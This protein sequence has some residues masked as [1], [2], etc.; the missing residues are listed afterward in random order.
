METLSD[1]RKTYGFLVHICYLFLLCMQYNLDT[2]K[3]GT[4]RK[5]HHDPDVT[6]SDVKFRAYEVALW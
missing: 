5:R 6:V 2:S 3:N 1:H 4:G